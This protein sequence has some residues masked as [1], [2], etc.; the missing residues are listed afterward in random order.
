LFSLLFINVAEKINIIFVSGFFF[1]YFLGLRFLLL[2]FWFRF[3]LLLVL[4]MS[5]VLM[6]LMVMRISETTNGSVVSAVEGLIFS[7]HQAAQHK[8]LKTTYRTMLAIWGV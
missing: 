1:L 5:M 3:L 8:Q 4:Y 6:A 2:L 7:M